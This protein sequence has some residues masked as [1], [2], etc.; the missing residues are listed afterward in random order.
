MLKTKKVIVLPYSIEWENNFNAICDEL[1]TA[2]QGDFLTIEHVG[3]TSVKGMSAKPII[4][5]DIVIKSYEV[6][7]AVKIK[8]ESIGYQHEGNL[9]IKDRE[10]F[11]YDGR[12]HLQEHHLYVCPE[13]SEELRRHL[14]FREYLRENPEAVME[15][16]TVKEEGAKLFPDDIVKYMQYKSS[17][18]EKLYKD[19]GL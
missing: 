17:L 4:D 1:S 5:I 8:L 3:S 19:C 16:S 14:T 7:E 18:I 15:Y 10:A 9:G 6:F 13:S 11:R 12:E 2:L